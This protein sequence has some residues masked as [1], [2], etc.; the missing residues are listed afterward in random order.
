MRLVINSAAAG[1]SHLGM[2]VHHLS[3]AVAAGP[4]GWGRGWWPRVPAGCSLA[5]RPLGAEGWGLGTREE[6]GLLAPCSWAADF[7]CTPYYPKL[8]PHSDPFLPISRGLRRWH[9]RGG[10]CQETWAW[11]QFYSESKK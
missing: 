8:Q 9:G 2:S 5:L 3:E 11:L 1:K 7:V 4:G 6:F 10:G